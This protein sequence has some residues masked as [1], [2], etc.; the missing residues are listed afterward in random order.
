MK[1]FVAAGF[2]DDL[3][4]NNVDDLAADDVNTSSNNAEDINNAGINYFPAGSRL[5]R[6]GLLRLPFPNSRISLP[7]RFFNTTRHLIKEI[8]Y[9]FFY[10][11]VTSS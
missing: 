5:Q 3:A 8:Y 11:L 10:L 2:V 1:V 6:P 7:S 9:R 4:A